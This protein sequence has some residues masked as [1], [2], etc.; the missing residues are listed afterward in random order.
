MDSGSG[1]LDRPSGPPRHLEDFHYHEPPLDL[2][3]TRGRPS[4]YGVTAPEDNGLTAPDTY[5]D[6]SF[7]GDTEPVSPLERQEQPDAR[8]FTVRS[9]A[10]ELGSSAIEAV[11]W[12]AIAASA[13]AAAPGAGRVVQ[14]IRLLAGAMDA[15]LSVQADKG[16]D[17]KLP[18]IGLADGYS[19]D[20]RV[21]LL[22]AQGA[23]APIG[24]NV[25][26]N[27]LDAKIESDGDGARAAVVV[28]R[29]GSAPAE[30][31]EGADIA[32][33][34]ERVIE[35]ARATGQPVSELAP[36]AVVFIDRSTM[37]A[38]V[39]TTVGADDRPR[40]VAT[41][42]LPLPPFPCPSCGQH[43]LASPEGGQC[44]ECAWVGPAE[45]RRRYLERRATR[46]DTSTP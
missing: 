5:A 4:D 1:S 6:D 12:N 33:L 11:M 16:F 29:P 13:D 39:T 30:V 38:W 27:T 2:W 43:T 32:R 42:D 34:V 44:V 21:R 24:I 15:V 28:E 9:F 45:A 18:M 36:F 7:D 31:G 14:G 3:I 10:R 23:G 35:H 20:L 8:Q 26:W 41:S 17:L 37:K 19:L 46:P 40:W 22:D 25:G